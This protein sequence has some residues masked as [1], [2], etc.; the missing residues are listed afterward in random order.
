MNKNTINLDQIDAF[1][2]GELNAQEVLEVLESAAF[3]PS[4]MEYI[5]TEQRVSS[6]AELERDYGSFLPVGSMAADDGRNLCDLQC[7]QFLLKKYGRECKEDKLFSEAKR[8]YWLRSQGTPLYNMGKLLEANGMVVRRIYDATT[9]MLKE[10]L[11][12]HSVIAV[13]NGNCLKGEPVSPFDEYTPNHAVVVLNVDTEANKVE[14]FNP[15]TKS[16]LEVHELEVFTLA[17]AESKNYMLEVREMAYPDEFIPNPI[18]VSDIS[19]SPELLELTDAIAENAH[20]VWAAEKIKVNPNLRYAPLDENGSEVPGCNHFF[21][22]YSL[23]SEADKKPDVDMALNT[24][25]LLKRLGY[26]IVDVNGLHRCP[27]C[28]STIEKHHLYC[29]HCGRKLEWQDFA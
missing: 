18:D 25:R 2:R 20:N 3:D 7:E 14:L 22:P 12:Q 9:D 6:A 11:A 28:G 15:D 4:I 16:E 17:W 8:N 27:E 10:S 13:V 23:L 5:V 29:S 26:R 21:R 1:L 24:I 19:L